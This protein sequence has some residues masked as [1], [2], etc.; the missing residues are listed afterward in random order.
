MNIGDIEVVPV[1]CGCCRL[2]GGAMF[3]VV[4]KVLWERHAPADEKNRI[5]I[6]L[7]SMLIRT[8]PDVVLVD[9]GI[10]EDLPPKMR[11]DPMGN[12]GSWFP[13]YKADRLLSGEE[14]KRLSQGG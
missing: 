2:D 8:G 5:V 6:A 10:G 4:P 12:G 11:Y 3:G 7:R 14:R 9:T 13:G 1:E